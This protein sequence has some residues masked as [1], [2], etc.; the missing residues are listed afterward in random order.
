MVVRPPSA[1]ASAISLSMPPAVSDAD[2]AGA[3]APPPVEAAGVD[4]AALLG[5][6]LAPP[7]HAETTIAMTANGAA[8]RRNDCFV[9]K[10]DLL[11]SWGVT[12]IRGRGAAG[13]VTGAIRS[14]P[15]AIALVVA[16]AD[17]S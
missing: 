3:L 14:P 11:W 17:S 6:G 8:R 9:V 15:V 1:L 12:G 16:A 4:G 5:E 7:L 13:A 10:S 2:A